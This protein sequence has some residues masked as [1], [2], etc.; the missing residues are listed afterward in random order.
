MRDIDVKIILA[1]NN[2][3]VATAARVEARRK[4][5]DAKNVEAIAREILNNCEES[6]NFEV[7]KQA[8]QAAIAEYTSAKDAVA[9]GVKNL[10]YLNKL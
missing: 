3:A 7:A 6:K 9:E 1:A 8:V 10:S 5:D 2:L 4:F